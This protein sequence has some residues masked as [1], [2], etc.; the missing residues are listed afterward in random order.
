MEKY[1]LLIPN[2]P[3]FQ[4]L[5]LNNPYYQVHLDPDAPGPASNPPS[6]SSR[7]AI[8]SPV[9]VDW[10]PFCIGNALLPP[11]SGGQV[12]ADPSLTLQSGSSTSPVILLLQARTALLDCPGRSH[13]TYGNTTSPP[14]TGLMGQFLRSFQLADGNL[15]FAIT[16]GGGVEVVLLNRDFSIDSTALY[17]TGPSPTALTTGDFNGDGNTDL[18]VAN[19]G[20]GVSSPGTISILLGNG[21]GTFRPAVNYL[22]DVYGFYSLATGDFN[23]DGKPDLIVESSTLTV[24]LGNGDGT[25]LTGPATGVAGGPLAVADFNH[26]GFDDVVIGRTT[27]SDTAA[28]GGVLLGNGNGTFQPIISFPASMPDTPFFNIRALAAADLNGDG[29]PDLVGLTPGYLVVLKGNGNGS[30][31]LSGAYATTFNEGGSDSVIIADFDG[32]GYLDVAVGNGDAVLLGPTVDTHSIHI[33]LGNGDCTL[34][35]SPFIGVAPAMGPSHKTGMA[36]ADFTGDNLP[37]VVMNDEYGDLYLSVN[38]GHFQFAEP[39]QIASGFAHPVSA[40]LSTNGNFDLVGAEVGGTGNVLVMLGNGNGTFQAVSKYPVGSSPS[41]IAVGN[42]NGDSEP[43]IAVLTTTSNGSGDVAVLLASAGGGF[44]AAVSYP[45]GTYPVGIVLGDF[46]GDQILDIAVLNSDSSISILINNGQGVFTPAASLMAGASAVAIAAGD[47]NGD[48]KIDLAVA[49]GNSSNTGISMFLGN[50]N[51]TFQP[52]VTLTTELFPNSLLIGDFNQDGIQDLAVSHQ[53]D[54]T[55]LFGQGGGSFAPEIGM[56]AGNYLGPL[57]LADFNA[58]TRPDLIAATNNG[59]FVYPGAA[60]LAITP[61][62]IT[63]ASSPTGLQVSIDGLACTTPCTVPLDPG[64]QHTIAAPPSVEPGATT[65]T[66]YGFGSWSDGGAASHTIT[67]PSSATT[68]TA[69]F[70]TEYLLTTTVS[71]GAEAGVGGTIQTSPA[72]SGGYFT[73]GAIVQLTA[74]PS[75]GYDFASWASSLT[76]TADP[77]SIAITAPRTVTARFTADPCNVNGQ[78]SVDVQDVQTMINGAIG[79]GASMDLSGDGIANVVDIQIVIDAVLNLGC[80]A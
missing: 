41:S 65:G 74:V 35:G 60:P 5:Y 47:L 53:L 44:S 30:F 8:N 50:G 49:Y 6:P 75:P 66:G 39:S 9:P 73:A 24:L 56:V 67:A 70:A 40:Q 62:S 18:A 12:T 79:L 59:M 16:T 63:L 28:V 54:T 37:D 69:T 51:G 33:L 68:Y 23:H 7:V 43:D 52:A 11:L 2:F 78:T 14:G 10:F 36:V 71:A 42:L 55:F 77:Q 13:N 31:Q 38:Q 46:N 29:N 57:A 48:N 64:G 34:Q 32:D 4:E 1:G 26:D 20:N 22:S 27:T 72:S 58:D 17:G 19:G 80:H 15:A 76:G 45:V 25:F 3:T 61:V 21:D